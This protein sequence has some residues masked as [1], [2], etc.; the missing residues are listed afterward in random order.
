[1]AGGRLRA[2]AGSAWKLSRKAAGSRCFFLE[3]ARPPANAPAI[4]F[5]AGIHGD[6]AAATEGLLA[7]AEKNP[8]ILKTIRPLIFPCLNPWGLVHNN[9]L[10]ERG[11]DLNRCYGKRKP[12]QIRDQI[13]VMEKRTFDLAL[14]L[15]EDYDAHGIYIYEVPAKKPYWA[16]KLLA[17]ASAHLPSDSRSR[18]EGRSA[19]NGIVRR[20]I[21][22]DLMPDWPEAFL[23]HFQHSGRTFTIETPSEMDIAL[24]VVA[25]V[26]VIE[27]AVA[28][29]LATR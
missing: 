1:M 20:K 27:T 24:R 23:L 22:P 9:R 10:D 7:W 26:A 14:T 15:H 3:A 25:H 21:S 17:A 18:I 6:E 16:E 5:S 13:L 8:A 12:P 19:K 2:P 29:C 4:Y 28:E 11:R